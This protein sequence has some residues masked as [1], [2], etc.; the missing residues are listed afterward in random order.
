MLD[1]TRIPIDITSVAEHNNKSDSLD[2]PKCLIVGRQAATVDI[3]IDHKSISRQHALLFYVTDDND[4]TSVAVGIMH[5]GGK[6]GTTIN[7]TNKIPDDQTVVKL[8]EGDQ[9]Q[10][11]NCTERVFQLMWLPQQQ[12]GTQNDNDAVQQGADAAS[13]QSSGAIEE[14]TSMSKDGNNTAETTQTKDTLEGLTGRARREAEIAAM[15][16]SLDETPTYVP[17]QASSTTKDSENNGAGNN[18]M[19][20]EL[21][22]HHKLPLSHRV[23]FEVAQTKSITA[24]AMDA[25]G[26]RLLTGSNDYSIQMYDFG[27]MDASHRAFGEL[28]LSSTTD[29]LGQ[30]PIVDI[31]YSPT[32][33]KFVVATTSSSCRVFDRDGH[34]M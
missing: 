28:Q 25:A 13:Q 20:D 5:V 8:K 30:F 10:F 26:S 18:E 27:G 14:D 19:Q 32:G 22:K 15:M 17:H 9:I 21:T 16:A 24:L 4:E 2:L 34:D 3:R 11:G 29:D 1:Q 7:G 33:D 12:Q 6:H 31:S 23:D